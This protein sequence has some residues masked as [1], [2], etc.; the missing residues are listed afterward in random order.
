MPRIFSSLYTPY[1]YAEFMEPIKESTEAHK[2]IEDEYNANMLIVD[3]LRQRAQNELQENPESKWASDIINYADKLEQYSDQLA[4]NGLGMGVKDNLMDMRKMQGTTL[5]PVLNAISREKEF[6][7]VRDKAVGTNMVFGKMPSIDEII[8]NPNIGQTAYN[9]DDIYAKSSKLAEAMSKRNI[10]VFSP[11]HY[12][13]YYDWYG[14]KKGFSN[15]EISVMMAND[16]GFRKLFSEIIKSSGFDSD[17]TLSNEQK[18]SLY[19]AVVAGALTGFTYDIDVN[20]NHRPDYIK[21]K[22]EEDKKEKTSYYQFSRS[23][24]KVEANAKKDDLVNGYIRAIE[25]L[26]AGLETGE[27]KDEDI[28]KMLK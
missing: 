6:Q 3:S 13:E 12:N 28:Q 27:Y 8:A 26:Q 21:P 2:K 15:D 1:T 16:P 14:K 25:D 22:A 23:L 7:S 4:K 24:D 10:E 9:W 17:T 20:Y 18:N 19:N 5:T 11:Q